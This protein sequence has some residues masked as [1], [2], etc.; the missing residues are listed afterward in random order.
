MTHDLFA[1]LLW[2]LSKCLKA[3]AA[4]NLTTSAELAMVYWQ[5]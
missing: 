4:V 3:S 1:L 5:M 2:A